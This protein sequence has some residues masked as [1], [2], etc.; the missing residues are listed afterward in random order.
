MGTPATMS[1]NDASQGLRNR[2]LSEE[3]PKAE[4]TWTAPNREASVTEPQAKMATPS[5]H[6]R[7]VS[8]DMQRGLTIGLMVFA[9]EIGDAY[10]H[11][12]HSPWNTT[13]FAD[14]VMPWFLFMVGTSMAFSLKKIQT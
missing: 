7:L 11:L 14:Y 9:D 6:E 1:E 3:P 4:A 10:P 5:K 12:N 2:L 13:T 8:L